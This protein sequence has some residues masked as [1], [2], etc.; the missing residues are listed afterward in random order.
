MQIK[1]F[2]GTGVSMKQFLYLD[3]DIVNSIIAQ[4]EKGLI[5]SLSREQES[6]HTETNSTQGDV[7]VDGK[8][9]GSL[10][11][12]AKA[13]ADLSSRI[14]FGESSSLL[15]ASHE[16]VSK[17]LH[18][19]SFDIAYKYIKSLN[20]DNCNCQSNYYGEYIEIN[21][22]FDFIDL[23][24]LEKLFSKDG[25]IEYLKKIDKEKIEAIAETEKSTMTREQLRT[26]GSL[27][28]SII[29][30]NVAKNSKQYDDIHDIIVAFRQV[31]PYS[32]MLVSNDGYLIPLE[33]KYFRI[34]PTDLGFKYGGKI[35]CV[36]MITNIIGEKANHHD[37]R[38]IFAALQFAVNEA[39]RAI[40]P[41]SENKLYI[42]HPIAIFL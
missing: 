11:K 30:Q 31:V 40:L 4:N 27:I 36:G 26:K 14:G 33:D 18:D 10:L 29:K 12:F 13:E 6:T 1:I 38:N 23:D 35:T 5:Q 2:I 42:I 9:G 28:K 39:L 25:F 37:D 20:Y 17:T 24:Y 32:K 3:S 19:A 41:T 8:I 15:S 7:S 16:L 22:V 34:N 21:R